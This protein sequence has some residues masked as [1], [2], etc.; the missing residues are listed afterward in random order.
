MAAHKIFLHLTW[1]TYRRQPM[2]D[3]AT[4]DFLMGYFRKIAI[5]ERVTIIALTMVRTHV[6]LL[7][8]SSP[9]IDVS[10]LVQ[11]LKGGSSHAANRQPTNVLGLRWNPEYSVTSVSPRL[12]KAAVEYIQ[13]QDRRHPDERILGR[14]AL[15]GQ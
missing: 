3:A 1:S 8:R 11:F 4:H 6:H 12:V 13:S 9:R 15:Q 2:I 14:P 7:L 5:Q 10:R